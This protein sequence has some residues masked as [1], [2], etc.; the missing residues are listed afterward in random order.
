MSLLILT[1]NTEILSQSPH[2]REDILPVTTQERIDCLKCEIATVKELLEIELE[3][4]C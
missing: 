2:F 1:K 3:S 4:K